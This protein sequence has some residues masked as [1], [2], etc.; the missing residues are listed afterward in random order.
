MPVS[1]GDRRI[2]VTL[3]PSISASRL[4]TL[5]WDHDGDHLLFTRSVKS[6]VNP[7]DSETAFELWRVP[8]EGGEPEQMGLTMDLLREIRV[9]PGGEQIAFTAGNRN[10]EVWIMENFL[11]R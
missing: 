7:N 11:P 1:G 10:A 6:P 9:S 8:S 3:S 2:L 4:L 5:A